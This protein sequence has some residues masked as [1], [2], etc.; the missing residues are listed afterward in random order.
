VEV[1]VRVGLVADADADDPRGRPVALGEQCLGT[2]DISAQ[3]PAGAVAHRAEAV[4]EV[5]EQSHRPTLPRPACA[6]GGLRRA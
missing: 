6:V 5:V 3:Q 1:R 2:P 4:E